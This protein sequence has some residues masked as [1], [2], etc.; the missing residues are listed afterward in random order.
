MKPT[1]GGEEINSQ[2]SVSK[3]PGYKRH[4]MSHRMHWKILKK[5]R[6]LKYLKYFYFT[7]T[8]EQSVSIQKNFFLLPWILQPYTV[9]KKTFLHFLIFCIFFHLTKHTICFKKNYFT[10]LLWINHCSNWTG[11]I[12]QCWIKTSSDVRW[13]CG[14]SAVNRKW[15]NQETNHTLMSHYAT[16]RLSWSLTLSPSLRHLFFIFQTLWQHEKKAP[17]RKSGCAVLMHSTRLAV[18]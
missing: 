8:I 7:F 12:R 13:R 9:E 17:W 2:D 11:F 1:P 16:T 4:S 18:V 3:W 5:Y 15:R 14:W 6:K 10:F